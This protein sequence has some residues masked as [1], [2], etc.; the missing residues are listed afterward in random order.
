MLRACD[1]GAGPPTSTIPSRRSTIREAS[2]GNRATRFS[3]PS[4]ETAASRSTDRTAA[5]WKGIECHPC[6]A[7]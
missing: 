3:R 1:R 4:M 6:A 2:A 5:S 7:G